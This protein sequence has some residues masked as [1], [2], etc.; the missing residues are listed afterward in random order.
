MRDYI[1]TESMIFA[2][3]LCRDLR[4][5]EALHANRI[6]PGTKTW[7]EAV[8]AIAEGF[9]DMSP[10]RQAAIVRDV[11]AYLKSDAA[12]EKFAHLVLDSHARKRSALLA[13]A[14][15]TPTIHPFVGNGEDGVCI[16]LHI[17]RNY[18]NGDFHLLSEIDLAFIS[19]HALARMH[20]RGCDL[21]NNK[22]TGIL[23]CLGILGLIVR[24]SKKH[25]QGEMSLRFGD[26][27]I[28]G[29]LKHAAKPVGDGTYIDG[30]LLD[31]RTVLAADGAHSEML[32]QGE[33]A[34]LA[35]ASW[36]EHR[37]GD[38]VDELAEQIPFR[39]RREDDHTMRSL[40]TQA[41]DGAMHIET[42]RSDAPVGG[43]ATKQLYPNDV[44]PGLR[45]FSNPME[46]Q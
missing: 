46:Q 25:R 2:K 8:P 6:A 21:S 42:R 38:N 35:V 3:Y 24:L 45:F 34:A 12:S 27:L 33:T 28:T 5:R 31:V 1:P 18:R 39:P 32:K 11:T 26:W 43:P 20:E 9:S 13:L 30:T 16:L 10:I 19:K 23:A 37:P 22:A 15:L 44:V 4:D 40:T 17:L 7:R 36:L 14:T 41:A 29:S